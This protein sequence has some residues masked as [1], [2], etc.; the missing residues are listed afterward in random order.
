MIAAFVD[1]ELASTGHAPAPTGTADRPALAPVTTADA[2]ELLTLQRAAFA[3][4]ARRYRDPS[5]PPLVQ[6]LDELVAELAEVVAV[7]ATLGTRLVGAV[8]GRVEGDALQVGRLV[9]APDLQGRGTGA[10]LLTA[11]EEAAPPQVRR[12]TLFTGALSESS[13]RLYGRLGYVEERREPDASGLL[14][15]HLAKQLRPA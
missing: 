6:T 9:V 15:V 8:R 10:A 14:L 2:G 11:L 13:L 7:K 1:L 12:A 3:A 5:L 4:E